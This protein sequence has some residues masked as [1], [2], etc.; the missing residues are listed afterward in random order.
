MDARALARRFRF[1]WGA[2]GT[3][4][5]WLCVYLMHDREHAAGLRAAIA[6]PPIYSSP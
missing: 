2:E 6:Q 1:P 3:P 4:Y 5:D